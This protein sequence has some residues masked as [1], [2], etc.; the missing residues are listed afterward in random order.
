MDEIEIWNF[1]KSQFG[2]NVVIA[3]TTRNDLNRLILHVGHSYYV[4]AKFKT[5]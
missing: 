2:A 4:I 5:T 1:V 3:L